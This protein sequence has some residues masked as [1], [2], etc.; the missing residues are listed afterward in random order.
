VT[1]TPFDRT[2]L[3]AAVSGIVVDARNIHSIDTKYGSEP[4]E[5]LLSY[6]LQRCALCS[7]MIVLREMVQ[8]YK[9]YVASWLVMYAFRGTHRGW[10]P[11]CRRGILFCFVKWPEALRDMLDRSGITKLIGEELL[12]PKIK[13]AVNYMQARQGFRPLDVIEEVVDLGTPAATISMPQQ[14][15]QQQQQQQADDHEHQH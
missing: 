6:S 5:C 9:S 10:Q 7:A 1:A 8:D 2:V 4:A 3:P 11:S 15:P 14:P 13:T 12:F